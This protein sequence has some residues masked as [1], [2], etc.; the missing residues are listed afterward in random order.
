MDTEPTGELDYFETY[1]YPLFYESIEEYECDE[2]N[3][4]DL[5]TRIDE[6]TQNIWKVLEQL[7]KHQKEANGHIRDSVE[8]TA[9]N[10]T[11]IA[12]NSTWISAIKKTIYVIVIALISAITT[13]VVGLW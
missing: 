12:R 3:N 5:L 2:M 11:Q 1:G 7:E 6:R 10:A 8:A 13:N 9:G 4:N